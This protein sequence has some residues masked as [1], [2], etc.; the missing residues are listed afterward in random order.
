[1]TAPSRPP[2]TPALAVEEFARWY[3]RKDELVPFCRQLGLPTSGSKPEVTARI[4]AALAGHA[5]TARVARRRTGTM[6]GTFSRDTVIGMGWRCN[7]ALGAFL[8][9]VCGPAFRFNL[10]MRTFIHTAVGATLEDAIECY[11]ASVAPGAPPQPML[12]QNEYNAHLREY[13]RAHPGSTAAE[14]RAAW[15]R[16]RQERAS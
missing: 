6:P 13:A 12:P 3:W 8:R 10:T 14:A 11:R 7:P 2:L 1:M 16:R 4:A 5:T 15:H 9:R